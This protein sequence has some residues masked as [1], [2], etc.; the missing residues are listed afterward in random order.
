MAMRR[1]SPRPLARWP[2][3]RACR[4][5]HGDA[6]LSCESLYKALSGGRKS[7]LDT[8]LKFV[9][10]LGFTLRAKAMPGLAA[11]GQGAATRR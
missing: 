7:G 8:V 1:S 10:T 9:G 4:G 3:P 5:S 2:A 6:D 11:A